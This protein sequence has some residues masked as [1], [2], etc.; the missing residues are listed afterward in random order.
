MNILLILIG[1]YVLIN[2]VKFLY[3][4]RSIEKNKNLKI[5]DIE[6]DY[7]KSVHI[8]DRFRKER[9]T[10]EEKELIARYEDIVLEKYCI[11]KKIAFEK[12]FIG[13]KA[14]IG[15]PF[16][17][18]L[19]NLLNETIYHVLDRMQKTFNALDHSHELY[20]REFH[21]RGIKV[22]IIT[23]RMLEERIIYVINFDVEAG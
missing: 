7:Q 16:N 5:L 11:S 4:V 23:D 10:V 13:S 20:S 22:P 2:Y 15:Y 8:Q 21:R 17:R 18:Y 3:Y 1:I 6:S 12:A 14:N 19:T 9:H